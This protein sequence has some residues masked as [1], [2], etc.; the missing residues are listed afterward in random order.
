MLYKP[1]LP[2]DTT[3]QVTSSIAALTS[4]LYLAS[5]LGPL[6]LELRKDDIL[7]RLKVIE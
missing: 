3:P 1:R 4:R 7:L 2:H 6:F 5:S